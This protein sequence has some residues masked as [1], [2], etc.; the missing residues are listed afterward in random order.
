M[1]WKPRA[2]TSSEP[3]VGNQGRAFARNSSGKQRRR[4]RTSRTQLGSVLGL[5]VACTC[6]VWCW[7]RESIHSCQSMELPAYAPI[8]RDLRVWD[9]K[10]NRALLCWG[11]VSLLKLCAWT[12]FNFVPR[13][14]PCIIHCTV[15]AT[16]LRFLMYSPSTMA[17]SV[18]VFYFGS[19]CFEYRQRDW[20]NLPRSSSVS[21]QE[22]HEYSV[23]LLRNL[24]SVFCTT[25]V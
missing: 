8:R 16:C 3:H 5:N 14:L 6:R 18:C 25:Y 12:A 20:P 13:T 7:C 1:E 11:H 19:A 2:I 22:C 21:S 4:S 24:Y 15:I 10:I 9:P 17:R 23:L